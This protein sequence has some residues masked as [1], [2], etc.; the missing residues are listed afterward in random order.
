MTWAV[1]Y[2]YSRD[3]VLLPFTSDLYNPGDYIRDYAEFLALK[4]IGATNEHE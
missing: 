3:G 2:K 4:K 1:Q